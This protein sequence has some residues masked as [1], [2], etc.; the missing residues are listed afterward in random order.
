MFAEIGAPEG[1]LVE[2]VTERGEPE[3]EDWELGGWGV[4][5]GLAKGLREAAGDDH[6]T[7]GGLSFQNLAYD[8]RYST[9]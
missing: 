8:A 6:D 3:V 2:C 4:G 5:A 9:D 7:D 1:I